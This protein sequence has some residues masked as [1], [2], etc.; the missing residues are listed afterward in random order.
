MSSHTESK[1]EIAIV[2]IACQYPGARDIRELWENI[3]TKRRQF[4]DMPDCRLPLSDYYDPDRLTPDKTYGKRAAVL[5]GFNFDWAGLRI[6]K[7]TF[8]AMD[9]AHWLA[10]DVALKSLHN[11]G[12]NAESVPRERTGVIVGNTLTGEFSRAEGLRLRWPFV[13]KALVAAARQRGLPDAVVNELSKTM[14]TYYKSV[15]TPMSE[16]SLAGGLSNTIAGRVCNFLNFNGGGYTVDGACASSLLAISTAAAALANRDLDFALAGGVD[17][18]L[19]T[20]ELIGFAKTGALTPDDMRVY[21]RRGNG[22]IPGEGCSFVVLKRLEDAL[23]DKNYV[24]AVIDGWGISSDG[25]GGITAPSAKGQALAINR[26][27]ERAGVDIGTLDFIEGHGTG[28]TVGDK[29]ELSGIALALSHGSIPET[30]LRPVGVT[31]F[32]SVVG[33]TKAAAGIGGFIKAVLAVNRRVL[34]PTA[35]CVEPNPVFNDI[36]TNIYPILQG[37]LREPGEILRAG[38]TG[39]GFGGI[40]CHVTIRSADAPSPDLEPAISEREL[41]VSH[42]DSELFVIGAMS[43]T[44]LQERVAAVQTMI[45]GMSEAEM[46][47]LSLRLTTELPPD[48]QCRAAVIAGGYEEIKQQFD[49]LANMLANAPPAENEI[50]HSLNHNIFIGNRLNH[51]R[52]G[53]LFPG[54][55]SQRL[56]MGRV[57]VERHAWAKALLQG[58]DHWL[59]SAGFNTLEQHIYK[60]L[61]RA[62]NPEQV[63]QWTTQLTQ[64]EIAQPAICLTSL[65]WQ[66]RLAQLGIVPVVAGGH[67]L[68]ELSAFHAAGAFNDEELMCLAALRGSAMAAKTDLSGGM[69]SLSC[70][71]STAIQLISEIKSYITVANINGPEQIVLSGDKTAIATALRLADERGIAARELAVSNAFHSSFVTSAAETLRERATIPRHLAASE[72]DII[73][74]ID[75]RKCAPGLDLHEH[76]ANQVL[77]QV[78]FISLVKT[79]Q[80]SCDIMVEVGPGSVLSSLSSTIIGGVG[81]T[82]YPVEATPGGSR[83][84]NRFLGCYFTRGGHVRWNALFSG[85]L[86]RTFTPAHEKKFLVSPCERPFN[87]DQDQTPLLLQNALPGGFGD[88]PADYLQQRGDFIRAVIEADMASFNKSITATN[89]PQILVA[90]TAVVAAVEPTV[91]AVRSPQQTLLTLIEGRTGFPLDS[92]TMNMRLLDDLNLDSIKAGELIAEVGKQLNVAGKIDPIQYTN[93]TLAEIAAIFDGLKEPSPAIT[94]PPT[95]AAPQTAVVI[96]ELLLQ[97][98][99]D[100]T[101]F[102]KTSLSLNMRLLDDLNL[103]S[104]KAAE[105]ISEAAKRLNLA[106]QIDP[107]KYANTSLT[108]IADALAAVATPVP[109]QPQPSPQQKPGDTGWV[110]NFTIELAKNS[111]TE[112]TQI[113]GDCIIFCEAE[114]Q[115]LAEALRAQLKQYAG[116]TTIA[117]FADAEN[118]KAQ[119]VTNY[120]AFLPRTAK[121]NLDADRLLATMVTRVRSIAAIPDAASVTYVQFGGGYFGASQATS[122]SLE[123]CCPLALASS[124]HLE[125]SGTKVRVLDFAQTCD[126]ARIAEIVTTELATPDEFSVAGYDMEF[127]R[128]QPRPVISYPQDYLPRDL[129]WSTDDLI[130]VTGGA[131]G[132]T[133]EC[134]IGL[135]QSKGVRLALVGSSHAGEEVQRT[136]QRMRDVGIDVRYY[137][138]D[139]TKRIAV[140]ALIEEISRRQGEITGVIHGAG[141]NR[142]GALHTVSA[143]DAFREISPKVLGAINL[144]QALQRHPPKIFIGFTS[145]IGISGMQRNGW[146]GFSNEALNLILTNFKEDHPKTH[147]LSLAFSIWGDVGMGVRL[148]SKEYLASK[149]IEAIPN[150]EGVTRFLHLFDNDPGQQQVVISAKLANLATWKPHPYDLPKANRY[151][152]KIR[153]YYPGVE[154]VARAHLTLERDD[155]LLEHNWRGTYL[156][157]TVFGLEAM[158]QAVA[159]V[160][161]IE[162]FDAFNIENVAL[163]RPIAVTPD[164]GLEIEIRAQVAEDERRVNVQITTAQTEFTITHFSA[165]FVLNPDPT[166]ITES[167]DIPATPTDIDPQLDLYNQLLFQGKRFQRIESVLE[168]DAR[169]G[170]LRSRLQPDDTYLLGDPFFRDA[171]LQSVQLP[172]SQDICLPVKIERILHYPAPTNPDGL[173]TVVTEILRIDGSNIHSRV[174]VING[175]G[176]IIEQLVGDMRIIESHPE[177]PTPADL[178]NPAQRDAQIIKTA[179]NKAADA[180]NMSA[181]HIGANHLPGLSDLPKAQRH[182]LERP[183]IEDLLAQLPKDQ[184]ETI[185]PNWLPNGRPVLEGSPDELDISLSHDRNTLL[186]VIGHG[187]QG[188]DLETIR[189][190]VRADW[191]ALLGIRHQPLF[192]QLCTTLTEDE[193]GTRIWSAREAIQ[194]AAG[195]TDFALDV[196]QHQGDAVLFAS[197]DLRVITTSLKLTRGTE[198][199]LAVTV[200]PP[201]L[202]PTSHERHAALGFRLSPHSAAIE[203]GPDNQPRFAFRFPVTFREAANISRTLYYSHYFTWMGKLREY[204]IQPTYTEIERLFATGQWGMVTNN[205]D[206]RIFDTAKSGDT[207][208]GRVWIERVTGK[209]DATIDLAFDWH[210]VNPDESKTLIA[211]SRMQT[212]WVEILGHGLVEVRPYPPFARAYLEKILPRGETTRLALRDSFIDPGAQIH[213]EA[214]GP[215]NESALLC[216]QVFETSLED[217]NLVGNIYFSHYYTWQGRARDNFFRQIAPEY[218]SSTRM[219]GEFRCSLC[220][221]EHL[222]E[223]MPFESIQVSLYRKAIHENAIQLHVEYHRISA[224]GTKQKLGYGEHWATWYAP[225]NANQWRPAKIPAVFIN[226]IAPQNPRVIAHSGQST[227][228]DCCIVGSGIGGLT[229]AALLA[230]RGIK[231]LVVEQ[232]NRPGGFCTSW[233]R[234]VSRGHKKLRYVF[235]AGVHDVLGLGPNSQLRRFL[236]ELS[237]NDIAWRR[238]NHEYVLPGKRLKVPRNVKDYI[239]LLCEHFPAEQQGI[240]AFFTEMLACEQEIFQTE[241]LTGQPVGRN[242]L[243]RWSSITYPAMLDKYLKNPQLKQLLGILTE[244]I[245][246]DPHT[247]DVATMAP[248]FDYYIYGGCY[249]CGSSQTLPT[250]LVKFI[251]AAGGEVRLASAVSRILVTEGKAAGIEL[252]DGKIINAKTVVSNA[253]VQHTFLNL[254]DADELPDHFRQRIQ[255]LKPSCSV[256][257]VFLGVDYVPDV[258][259]ITSVL[260]GDHGSDDNV[261]LAIP[262]LVDPSLAPEGHSCITLMKTI[263]HAEAA[264]WNRDA[265]DYAERKRTLGDL[266]IK[267]AEH[268]LP[269]L[270]RHII[271]R[272]EASPATIA[273]YIWSTAGAAYSLAINEWHPSYKTPVSGLYLTGVATR[274]RP[275]VEDAIRSG[276]KAADAIAEHLEAEEHAPDVNAPISSITTAHLTHQ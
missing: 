54:Q 163:T 74:G 25:K 164:V 238:M 275:G 154:L 94:A 180:V 103:D 231:T 45:K 68:G 99:E 140:F 222:S 192:A 105:L 71:L 255:Q 175:N 10:L 271:F 101:G 274:N 212:T 224:D 170:L 176:Q 201:R 53:Y 263:P 219:L 264:S 254:V 114:E 22:F 182:T 200:T 65:L 185:T 172:M 228:Y 8:E 1:S 198:R 237:I 98:V 109:Q 266:L 178:A 135:A 84:L 171:M 141:V 7:T 82:C 190:R 96:P 179:I 90:K 47:D 221:I 44:D 276:I 138:C 143:T 67:S 215:V 122:S 3:L 137:P 158:A 216:Q 193:A 20:F 73:S 66:K 4:R 250:K 194:K 197:N 61:D 33:H 41:L 169:H 77:S 262:S 28:T 70:P 36:A 242:H 153:Y 209:H 144:C 227:D 225:N 244:Y 270:S 156:F 214:K 18:S 246:D 79:L 30:T 129:H 252:A 48:A 202:V 12:Y 149:G 239:E 107:I 131:K 78:D 85:R 173:H 93:A 168:L 248:V 111:I 218:F 64:T 9:I 97:L 127:I 63:K 132:I 121:L 81:P 102:P 51:C 210:R 35:N 265:P 13:N 272:E 145:I 269:G 267:A 42:H 83:D 229:T 37:S 268:A 76:F 165:S 174:C 167:V 60:P 150:A 181:P 57:L 95:P 56:N 58:A 32:K 125:R 213:V 245:S 253:D 40:N 88:L 247:I 55:G 29:T 273:R 112:T 147:T 195:T 75:G 232:H 17:I 236:N 251:R 72:I 6:P 159:Y 113:V 188:C 199:I 100:R 130:L 243:A 38:V 152:E 118:S 80:S 50:T 161:G 59:R 261:S 240:R 106:G 189:P 11:A 136:L 223:A 46:V 151:L 92:L 104:I 24:Y 128:R 162:R 124:L 155:Y 234:Q 119:G 26:A 43:M 226:A 186:C 117:H 184:A 187:S 14:E 115:D 235:D 134:A 206:I 62:L 207:I 31:S 211:E 157:P 34:P 258:E 23:R 123:Q 220:K 256:F 257:M 133:A 21:D 120:I 108:E 86:T 249:P 39:A 230:K 2:G 91:V 241:P 19:D 87:V 191:I 160:A 146:Y 183:L 15:F 116:N 69:V 49:T 203:N 110:R 217:A 233:N 16:D 52:V 27:Y 148:G 196:D 177:Y 89:P 126:A 204:L 259:P 260:Y 139:I 208:E 205:S 142:P 166:L 5:D